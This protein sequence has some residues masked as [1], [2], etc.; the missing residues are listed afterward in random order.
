M[1]EKNLHRI[2]E[3]ITT[4]VKKEIAGVEWFG[5]TSDIWS[6][7][8]SDDSMISLTYHWLTDDFAKKSAVLHVQSFPGSHTGENIIM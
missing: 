5:F 2:H 1:T 8:V 6:T 3:A 7:S 4:E